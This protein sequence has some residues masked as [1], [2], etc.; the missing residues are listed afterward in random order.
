MTT[1]TPQQNFR[2]QLV[3]DRC[4]QIFRPVECHGHTQCA[5]CGQIAVGGDC[6][7]GSQQQSKTDEI[8]TTDG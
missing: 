5:C 6:C 2:V 8:K 3:C 7:Q 1:N 4:G